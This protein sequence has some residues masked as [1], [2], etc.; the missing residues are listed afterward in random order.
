MFLSTKRN[1]PESL[2]RADTSFEFGT[3]E[4]ANALVAGQLEFRP[5]TPCALGSDWTLDNPGVPVE[6]CAL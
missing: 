2:K 4:N 1:M 5:R 6:N 3:Q